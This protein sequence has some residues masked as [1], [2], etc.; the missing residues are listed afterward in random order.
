[1]FTLSFYSYEEIKIARHIEQRTL[2]IARSCNGE[3]GKVSLVVLE[4]KSLNPNSKSQPLHFLICV[5]FF[6]FKYFKSNYFRHLKLSFRY[7]IFQYLAYHQCL[8]FS[9]NVPI[10]SPT[11][12]S[13]LISFTG[14][15]GYFV[16]VSCFQFSWFYDSGIYWNMCTF[17]NK[18]LFMDLN[19]FYQNTERN[20]QIICIYN[21]YSLM[22]MTPP[23]IV[24]RVLG[25][26]SFVTDLII[27]N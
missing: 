10:F 25:Q 26:I 23:K 3:W 5:W 7:T 21:L 16:G 12:T 15:F 18:Q 17:L 4:P 1:M 9:A 6:Y 2:V 22:W 13:K 14:T 27:L 11:L 19:T 24:Q 20:T 8:L